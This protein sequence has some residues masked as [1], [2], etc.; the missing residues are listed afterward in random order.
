MKFL[1]RI[2]KHRKRGIWNPISFEYVRDIVKGMSGWCNPE[3]TILFTYQVPEYY[4]GLWEYESW[5]SGKFTTNVNG[6]PEITGKFDF[7]YDTTYLRWAFKIFQNPKI[8]VPKR[9]AP[10]IIHDDKVFFLIAPRV[11][12]EVFDEE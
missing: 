3:R 6:F 2:C 4:F 11:E 8:L 5:A 7:S 9:E 1:E 12:A 10:L